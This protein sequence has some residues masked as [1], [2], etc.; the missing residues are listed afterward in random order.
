MYIYILCARIS[1]PFTPSPPALH[2]LL[3]YYRTTIGPYT[4]PQRPTPFCMPYPI[5][6]FLTIARRLRNIRPTPPTPSLY[7]IPHPILALAISCKKI[8]RS[9][10]HTH[11]HTHT[12]GERHLRH[13]HTHTTRTTPQTP[14]RTPPT[15]TCE[16][17]V[18]TPVATWPLHDIAIT[19][20]EW[21]MAYKRRFGE[22]SCIAQ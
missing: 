2:T 18:S 12:D 16:C 9:H 6:Y 15:N 1:P 8:N 3:Q 5:Q 10:T 7:A 19:N 4:T 14:K 17:R 22:G 20:I 11:T 13:R 21:C